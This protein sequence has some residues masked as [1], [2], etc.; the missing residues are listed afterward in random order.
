MIIRSLNL[1]RLG[2]AAVLVTRDRKDVGWLLKFS[3][4]KR[5]SFCNGTPEDKANRTD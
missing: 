5:M 2:L 3:F 1:R 4:T